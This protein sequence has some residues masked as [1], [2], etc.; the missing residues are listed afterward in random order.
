MGRGTAE[1]VDKL[2][3]TKADR[4]ERPFQRRRAGR[5]LGELILCD[6]A[7][8]HRA[9]EPRAEAQVSTVR[10]SGP[11]NSPWDSNQ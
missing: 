3:D 6:H 10:V 5:D 4:L 2:T 11:S 1:F 7:V 9:C 8:D